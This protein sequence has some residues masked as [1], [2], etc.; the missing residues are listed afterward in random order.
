MCCECGESAL[1]S[2]HAK[3][4]LSVLSFDRL[5]DCEM[6]SEKYEVQIDGMNSF[7]I[8]YFALVTFHFRC[9]FVALCF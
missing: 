3:A 1:L 2:Y 6:Q 5:T 4:L 8:L 7:C 9:G